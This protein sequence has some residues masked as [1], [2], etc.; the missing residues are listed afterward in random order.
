MKK[1]KFPKLRRL[2]S[3]AY[4]LE[5]VVHR[6]SLEKPNSSAHVVLQRIVKV[7]RKYQSLARQFAVTKSDKLFKRCLNIF[8]F[9]TN[10]TNMYSNLKNIL[11][12]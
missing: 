5:L 10:E 2:L 11:H 12:D 3:I 9:H 8:D 6:L 4:F 1:S 7:Y